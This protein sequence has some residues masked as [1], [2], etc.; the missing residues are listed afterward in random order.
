MESLLLFLSDFL[1]F[2][3][4]TW[5]R[6]VSGYHQDFWPLQ[7]FALLSG[8]WILWLVFHPSA[9]SDRLISTVLC[10]SWSWVGAVFHFQYFSTISWA[11]WAFGGLFLLQAALFLV[12]GVMLNKI[13]YLPAPSMTRRVA[14]F[15]V[16]FA[17]L[18]WPAITA[19]V[20]GD[21]A[22]AGFFGLSADATSLAT[23]GFILFARPVYR[24]LLLPLPLIWGL[25][26]IALSWTMAAA[27][28]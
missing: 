26:S 17:L 19:A 20:S 21:P 18:G 16:L 23:I 15:I 2:L 25:I 22:Q 13:R 6:L 8:L 7:I 11:A 12:F 14:V 3:P 24:W 27:A 1:M 5:S 4:E 10:A 9:R 28:G